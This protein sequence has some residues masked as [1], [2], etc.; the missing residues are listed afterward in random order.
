LGHPVE[1][2]GN[3]GQALLEVQT[4]RVERR[5]TA[6]RERAPDRRTVPA[7]DL[8][9]RVGAVLHLPLDRAYPAHPL[10]Q[11][12]LRVPI[13]LPNRP[14]GFSQIMKLAELMRD[15]RQ[16]FGHRLSD[17]LLAIADHAHHRH[18]L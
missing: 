15:P 5:L 3:G 8:G 13:G 1:A 7:D 9:R 6:I 11:C 17:G 14:T 12:L 10:A 4:P 18:A 16:H 2:G